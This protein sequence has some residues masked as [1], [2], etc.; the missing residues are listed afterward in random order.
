MKKSEK[1]AAKPD[2]HKKTIRKLWILA[3]ITMVSVAG[4]LLINAHPERPSLFLYIMSLRLPA[5]LCMIIASLSIGVATLIF[6]SIVNNRIVTPA[7][8]GMNSIYTFLH[9]AAVFV[10]GTGSILFVNANVSF[11]VDMVLMGTVATMVYWYLFKK[12]G[13]N[14]LYIMLIGTVLSSFFGS[15][16]SAMIRVMDP[17]E[18]DALLG[19]LVA[20]FTNVNGEIILF[21]VAALALIAFLL[22]KEL[23]LLDVITMGRDQAINLGVDYDNTIR[24]LLFGVV[25]C[26]AVATATVGPV[27]FLGLI[28]ANLSRQI[29]KTYRHSHLILGA[30][31]MGM[32]ALIGGQLVSQHIFHFTVPVSTFVTIAG[33]L[34][35]LYLLLWKKG[36]Y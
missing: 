16:Q 2:R 6:Q 18:Y 12:T 23:A 29:L 24:K 34:Y 35:F 20:D 4:Y 27:S 7:L 21:T 26:I 31:L 15:M 5:L 33:G 1:A 17:N 13:H 36:A 28:V 10:F 22:R 25:I 11:A 8:L 3:V 30:S 9:T 14:I 19:N 32:I